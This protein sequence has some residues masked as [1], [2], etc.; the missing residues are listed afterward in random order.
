MK[1]NFFVIKYSVFFF[2]EKKLNYLPVRERGDGS[3]NDEPLNTVPDQTFNRS[4]EEENRSGK[5]VGGESGDK[6][7]SFSDVFGDGEIVELHLGE[8]H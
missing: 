2:L 7:E 8:V 3:P 5:F 6:S 1:N 4:D